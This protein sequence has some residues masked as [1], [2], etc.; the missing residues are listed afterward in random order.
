M[1]RAFTLVEVLVVA[2]IIVILLAIVLSSLFGAKS[3]AT[4]VSCLSNQKQLFLAHEL[5]L[6]DSDQHFPV[7]FQQPVGLDEP[8]S[9]WPSWRTSLDP[10]IKAEL[11][12]P[13]QAAPLG[14]A[15][16]FRWGY[17]INYF[18]HT[19]Q[20]DESILSHTVT[21]LSLSQVSVPSQTVLFSEC[22]PHMTVSLNTHSSNFT[23][24]FYPAKDLIDQFRSIPPATTRH[25]GRGNYT[26]MDGSVKSLHPDQL[27]NKNSHYYFNFKL[28]EESE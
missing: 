3:K 10:Y 8:L 7:L 23:I 15:P 12:C 5:Y 11:L 1:R 17:S 28:K 22:N 16:N 27:D 14:I 13:N 6:G 18:T 9:T 25:Q 26:L 21:P 19:H 20:F 24:F 4:Q 2:A